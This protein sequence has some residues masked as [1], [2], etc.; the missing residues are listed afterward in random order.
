MRP[1][2]SLKPQT[3]RRPGCR[4][5]APVVPHIG[6]FALRTTASELG[7]FTFH[8][9]TVLWR[10]HKAAAVNRNSYGTRR[11][12]NYVVTAWAEFPCFLVTSI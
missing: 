12:I 10:S 7:S 5:E 3:G 1:N 6:A 9:Q 4:L 2:A 11:A 8:G